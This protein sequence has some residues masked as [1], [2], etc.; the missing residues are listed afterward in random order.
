MTHKLPVVGESS[1]C[2]GDCC[3]GFVLSTFDAPT[4]DGV[5][6]QIRDGNWK[7][8]A[9]I[10]DML[11]PYTGAPPD[12]ARPTTYPR[13]TCKHFIDRRCSQYEK[14]PQMCRDFGVTYYCEFDRCTMQPRYSKAARSEDA[15]A[16][17]AASWGDRH[18]PAIRTWLR[19][20]VVWLR[21]VEAQESE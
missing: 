1:E 18:D 3:N 9:Y 11:L 21:G 4:H 12:G 7:D 10:A 14:R 8:G 15:R 19:E 2:S 17:M 20:M 5:I 16:E 6:A 13:F